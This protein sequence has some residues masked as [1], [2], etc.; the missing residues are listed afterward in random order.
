MLR[1]FQRFGKH[2]TCHLQDACV[3]LVIFGSLVLDIASSQ[4]C[5][6]LQLN[7]S[8]LFCSTSQ[9]HHIQSPHPLPFISLSKVTSQTYFCLKMATA[10]FTETESCQHSM[11]LT[12]K[13]QEFYIELSPRKPKDKD[14]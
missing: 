1:A 9:L 2:C 5:A 14:I 11:W 8:P 13:S 10:V 12:P 7:I 4:P 6:Q 3:R